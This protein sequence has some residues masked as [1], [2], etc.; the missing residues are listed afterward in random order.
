MNNIMGMLGQFQGF[1]QNPLAFL[2]Q[3]NINVPQNKANDPNAIIQQMMDSGMVN[4]NQY[5]QAQQL[6]RQMQG[7]P[8]FRQ[9]FR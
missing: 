4:Q 7:N 8:A 9:F 6:Y 5:N 3:R 2:M 1:M